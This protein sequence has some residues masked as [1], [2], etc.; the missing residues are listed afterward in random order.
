[1]RIFFVVSNASIKKRG[2][3]VWTKYLRIFFSS[4]HCVETDYS[5][6]LQEIITL[7]KNFTFYSDI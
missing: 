6:Y 5:Q 3:N 4:R 1:M 7:E 2:D